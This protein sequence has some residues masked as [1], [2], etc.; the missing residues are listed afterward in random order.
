MRRPTQRPATKISADIRRL[1][2]LTHT[3][4]EA[5]SG[6]EKVFWQKQLNDTIVT[7][8]NHGNQQ[9]LDTSLD[10]L[11]QHDIETYEV[12]V[13]TIEQCSQSCTAEINETMQDVLLIAAPVLAWTRFS[14][15]S[16][17]LP[18][19]TVK[20]LE[21]LMQTHIFAD[22]ATVTLSPSLSAI[23]Q[24][25]QHHSEVFG[26]M[27]QLAHIP[28]PKKGHK[29]A[30][31]PAATIPFLADTRYLIA[32][33]SVPHQSAL[34]RWQ[35]TKDPLLAAEQKLELAQAWADAAQPLLAPALPGCNLELLLPQAYF[36]NCREADKRIR[37]ATI[38]AA[39]HYLTHHLQV[40]PAELHVSIGKCSHDGDGEID[41]YRIGFT[42][43]GE[44]SIYYGTV[45]PLYESED[46]DDAGNI[47][48]MET[49]LQL[50]K[51]CGI[52]HIKEHTEL[53]EA[54]CCDDCG[55]PL[56]PNMDGELV[57]AEMPEETLDKI[58]QLH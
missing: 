52:T 2:A 6:L 3:T 56:F 43:E 1:V 4:M 27:Q 20:S 42:K 31:Q 9:T 25:P 36:F 12:L 18:D 14:I 37:P 19:A 44:D 51:E 29:S 11:F 53:Y 26:L 10:Y 7:L 50:L 54:E 47:H 41:E 38:Y 5:V 28:T 16:G 48:P 8:L 46:G 15:S 34:F 45:W 35:T 23:E 58:E 55:S 40:L 32:A 13:E 49:I 33:V 39:T 30:N 22:G 57:H 17:L 24:L 21:Q